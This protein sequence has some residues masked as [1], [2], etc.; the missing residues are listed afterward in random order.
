MSVPGL[1]AAHVHLHQ[2]HTTL[3]Q[4]TSQQARGTVQVT[5]VL[6]SN[7]RRLR[8][9]VKRL[10]DATRRK[11]RNGTFTVTTQIADR[12]NPIQMPL[13]TLDDTQQPRA[14]AQTTLRHTLGQ[15]PEFESK[16]GRTR[17][18]CSPEPRA[19]GRN[20][21]A[22]PAH[23]KETSKSPTS[24]KIDRLP[25]EPPQAPT[26][27]G[28]ST[29]SNRPETTDDETDADDSATIDSDFPSIS[30]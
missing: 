16:S 10:A 11:Q 23:P 1:V 13:L 18:G 29:R 9:Q 25:H 26:H 8:R 17:R 28:P 30:S 5:A 22:G 27:S 19:W 4:T 12:G 6:R 15:R 21:R 3:D 2:A 20:C 24:S 7:R 14:V